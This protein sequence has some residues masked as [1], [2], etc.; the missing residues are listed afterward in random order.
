MASSEDAARAALLEGAR[1]L[2]ERDGRYDIVRLISP[3][4]PGLVALA[5]DRI[6]GGAG[7]AIKFIQAGSTPDS[8]ERVQQAILRHRSLKHPHIIAFDRVFLAPGKIGVAM[9]FGDS[10]TLS[11]YLKQEQRIDESL[12]RWFL[13]QVVIAVEFC[14]RKGFTCGDLNLEKF[15]LK[16]ERDLYLPSVKLY[17]FWYSE[18]R[19]AL[20]APLDRIA[21]T[22][23]EVIEWWERG[24]NDPGYDA[25]LANVWSCG[26]MLYY[27][28]VGEHAF[29]DMAGSTDEGR[30]MSVIGKIKGLDYSIPEGV[31]GP[32][33]DLISKCLTKADDRLSFEGMMRHEWIEKVPDK[34]IGDVFEKAKQMNDDIIANDAE[35]MEKVERNQSRVEILEIINAHMIERLAQDQP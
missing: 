6:S 3:K 16:Q 33:R 8:H 17:D 12:A 14:H 5:R 24:G 1:Q 9:E 23:P 15:L 7:R 26:A 11:E 31:H 32:C 10:G 20:R 21:C 27:M 30:S 13:Q 35:V 28:I 22:A 25:R 19:S 34:G 2:T 4:S 18:R 29:G